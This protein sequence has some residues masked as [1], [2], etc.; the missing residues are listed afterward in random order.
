MI[1]II[2]SCRSLTGRRQR[3]DRHRQHQR[4]SCR[5]HLRISPLHH[6]PPKPFGVSPTS[7]DPVRTGAP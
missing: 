1:A 5:Q 6:Q 4:A 3:R 7:I 2:G